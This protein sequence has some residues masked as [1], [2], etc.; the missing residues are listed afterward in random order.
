MVA[1]HQRRVVRLW[2]VELVVVL[3]GLGVDQ[4]T[5]DIRVQEAGVSRVGPEE[6]QR[7]LEV[8]VTVSERGV[9]RGVGHRL[10]VVIRRDLR[11]GIVRGG[12]H[13]GGVGVVVVRGLDVQL[14]RS[15]GNDGLCGS[16]R[17]SDVMRDFRSHGCGLSWDG[18]W[19]G[20]L[21]DGRGVGGV[22]NND[23]IVDWN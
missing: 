14:G 12:V 11:G 4:V 6:V 15:T 8:V 20:G 5:G 13:V 21:V 9:G 18:D 1:L 19:L 3:P 7:G 22:R 10:V 2:S 23:V 17:G 16:T